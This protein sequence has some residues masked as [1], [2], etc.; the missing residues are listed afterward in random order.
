M[1]RR[2]KTLLRLMVVAVFTLLIIGRVN[3]EKYLG[4]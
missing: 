2:C 3:N 4:H 1:Q